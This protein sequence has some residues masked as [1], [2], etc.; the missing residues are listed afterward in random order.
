[1]ASTAAARSP[2]A[3]SATMFQ[4]VVVVVVDGIRTKARAASFILDGVL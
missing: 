4:Y 1:M 3:Y 2:P